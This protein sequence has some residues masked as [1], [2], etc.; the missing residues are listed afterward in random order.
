MHLCTHT[1]LSVLIVSLIIAAWPGP[2]GAQHAGDSGQPVRI[3]LFG[4]SMVHGWDGQVGFRYPLWF[5]LQDAGYNVDFVGSRSNTGEVVNLAWYPDY[6]TSFDRDHQG[7]ILARTQDLV[8]PAATSASLHR[9]HV[10][11]VMVGVSDLYYDGLAGVNSVRSHLPEIIDEIRAGVPSA[12]IVMGLHQPWLGLF[13]HPDQ[14]QHVE[15]VDEL[16]DAIVEV[17]AAMDTAQSPIHLVDN[18]SGFDVDTMYDSPGDGLMPN[19]DGEA[20]IAG[21][22]FEVLEEVLPAV[23]PD[24]GA[25]FQINAGLT[26]AWFDPAT[27]GQGFFFVVFPDIRKLFLSWFTYDTERPDPAVM[28]GLGE[29]GHRWLT[30]TGDYEGNVA[31]LNVTLT[32]GGLFDSTQPEP[33]NQEGYGSILIEFNG[34]NGATLSYSF[35]QQGLANVLQVQRI[36]HDNIALCEALNAELQAE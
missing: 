34:C 31:E 29:P 9:P 2:A 7:L 14:N 27:D 22:F 23:D 8:E 12:P 32:S 18:Y 11:V 30:A 3:M 4:D 5:A 19:L 26:D 28:A 15:Y 24:V 21:N 6:N 36:A 17:A 16:N 35:P 33:T 10:V 13:G 25:S 1:R 20:W